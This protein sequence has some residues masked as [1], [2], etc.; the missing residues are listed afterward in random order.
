LEKDFNKF[1][2]LTE[3][4]WQKISDEA[5]NLIKKMLTYNPSFRISA[6]E[7]LNDPWIQRNAPTAALNPQLLRN[8]VGFYVS[9]FFEKCNKNKNV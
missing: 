2:N 5:K 4:D 7:A 3:G 8:I 6:Q 9:F 1:G